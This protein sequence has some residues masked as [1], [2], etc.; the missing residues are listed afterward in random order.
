MAKVLGEWIEGSYLPG[1]TGPQGITGVSGGI[2]LQGA[3]GGQGITGYSGLDGLMGVTGYGETGVQGLTGFKGVR[4]DNG[5]IVGLT[6]IQGET[7]PS[8]GEKGEIGSTGIQG[9]TGFQGETG[10]GQPGDAG[11]A[12]ATGI[13]G[14]TGL[15]GETGVKGSTGLR[16]ITGPV[17]LIGFTGVGPQGDQGL[18]GA[19]GVIGVTGAQ[20]IDGLQGV[21]GLQGV[22]GVT[23]I[24]GATGV[25]G[26]TGI[27][28]S[29][30]YTANTAQTLYTERTIE[31]S[32]VVTGSASFDGSS[33]VEIKTTPK[34][35]ILYIGNKT[36]NG[37]SWSS[38]TC[39][40][41]VAT[42]TMTTINSESHLVLQVSHRNTTTLAKQYGTL[43][44]S[45]RT[46]GN[47]TDSDFVSYAS[48]YWVNGTSS[49]NTIRYA[50]G[51][52]TS[53]GTATID[54]WISSDNKWET[55]DYTVV[56]EG[57]AS[58]I[59][60]DVWTVYSYQTTV[61]DSKIVYTRPTSSSYIESTILPLSSNVPRGSYIP[62]GSGYWF[63]AAYCEFISTSNKE[64]NLSIYGS[65][66]VPYTLSARNLTYLLKLVSDW[67][68]S[69]TL[70]HTASD[71]AFIYK[72]SDTQSNEIELVT[73]SNSS[74]KGAVALWVRVDSSMEG[75]SFTVLEEGTKTTREGIFSLYPNTVFGSN[76]YGSPTGISGMTIGVTQNPTE[77]TAINADKVDGYHIYAGVSGPSSSTATISFVF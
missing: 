1:S 61:N 50:L 19:T 53:A 15:Q 44:I 64:I 62:V 45:F 23:G 75:R 48:A 77:Y 57:T 33:N 41:K 22:T 18:K 26:D 21:I 40:F 35:G 55:I 31:L 34:G 37:S 42:K 10:V 20:G 70:Q 58:G 46:K 49:I 30:N 59:S 66:R 47:L 16:G 65:D 32:G 9:E 5:G 28:G 39:W 3:T 13:Q 54:V 69:T 74:T 52:T 11:V 63:C 2:G 67:T 14:A 29:Q 73:Y 76:E 12:G 38:G 7:G 72:T 24:K 4:G 43:K 27:Q 25:Q 60:W 71:L 17:G 68:Y 6:G 51:K 36:I 8:G 56:D